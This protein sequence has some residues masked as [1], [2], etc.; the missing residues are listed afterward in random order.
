MF[1]PITGLHKGKC[2]KCDTIFEFDI[3]TDTVCPLGKSC[4]SLPSLDGIHRKVTC[5]HCLYEDTVEIALTK[6]ENKNETQYFLTNLAIYLV[7]ATMIA[8]TMYCTSL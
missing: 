4:V 2:I 6:Y 8:M 5:P 3:D 7:T 1:K